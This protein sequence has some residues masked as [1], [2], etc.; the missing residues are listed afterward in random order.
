MSH[1]ASTSQKHRDA[2]AGCLCCAPPTGAGTVRM[3]SSKNPLQTLP[4]ASRS[5]LRLKDFQPRSMLHVPK[6][7][8]ERPRFPA[9]DMHTHLSWSSQVRNGVSVGEDITLFATA[10][11]RATA[12][13][14]ASM[15]WMVSPVSCLP[16]KRARAS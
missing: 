6:T 12:T 16:E 15:N 4:D 10:K 11:S 3:Q 13:P 8:V 5:E 1:H 9:I 2:Q 14:S 7:R